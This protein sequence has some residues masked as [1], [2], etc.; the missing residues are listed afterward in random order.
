MF[1]AEELSIEEI[2]GRFA[3]SYL[4]PM[5]GANFYRLYEPEYGMVKF[6]R[7]GGI[8]RYDGAG[9]WRAFKE[10]L[11]FSVIPPREVYGKENIEFRYK[12][13]KPHQLKSQGNAYRI[14]IDGGD[15]E[16]S[17]AITPMWDEDTNDQAH[18]LNKAGRWAGRFSPFY[19]N[20]NRAAMLLAEIALVF[21]ALLAAFWK[22]RK[23]CLI[24]SALGG[25]IFFAMMLAT[26]SRGALLG[27]AA[28]TLAIIIAK[29]AMLQKEKRRKYFKVVILAVAG[30]VALAWALGLFGKWLG[31]ESNQIRF[32]V[33]REVPRM[34]VDAP[35]G[36]RFT[37]PGLA[38]GDW[39]QNLTSGFFA[40]T[41]ISSHF[42]IMAKLSWIGRFFWVA[43]WVA[44]IIFPFLFL[45][46]KDFSAAGRRALPCAESAAAGRRALP[47]AKTFAAASSAASL[48]ACALAPAFA[49]GAMFNPILSSWTLWIIPTLSLGVAIV[50]NFR[51]DMF[52][53]KWSGAPLGIALVAVALL[54]MLGA[55][56]LNPGE[57]A[58]VEKGDTVILNGDKADIWIADD[59]NVL[60]WG[61]AP[62]EIRNFLYQTKYKKPIGYARNLEALPKKT[63][64]LL[65]AGDLALEYLE[66]WR[67][68]RAPR[69][70][71]L[72]FISPPFAPD[73]VPA[74]LRKSCNFLFVAGEFAFRYKDIYGEVPDVDWIGTVPGAERYIPGW[75]SLAVE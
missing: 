62:K 53:V 69:A 28:G 8:D 65:V 71:D 32:E 59:G 31:E 37:R 6:R 38:F 7:R 12:E 42:E 13:G 49:V 43:G 16:Y 55:R 14:E 11:S 73:K 33:W 34:L 25:A 45:I 61:Y 26:K 21:F 1:A 74:D 29:V 50:L 70:K 44:A 64:K 35:W 57:I 56:D 22:R 67:K 4:A 72:V 60:G 52:F 27:F 75:V 68:K 47:C 51:R 41:L 63:T 18:P 39:Y 5:D 36:W 15:I 17:G 30:V 2:A 19:R 23:I 40:W 24:V 3:R 20:P 10:G 48:I 9:G 46:R 54:Y 58:I 66:L